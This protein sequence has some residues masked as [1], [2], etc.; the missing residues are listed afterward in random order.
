MKFTSQI[1]A[2]GSGSIGGCTYSRNR[3]GQYI[4]R[5]AMPV[6]PGS[7]FAQVMT[8][9][10][11]A[12]V[13][14]WTTTLTQQQ[15]DGWDTWALNTPQTDPLGNA[16]VWTGQNAY[17]SMNS[18]RLQAGKTY[19]DDA[20]TIFAGATYTP[21][22]G[23]DTANVSEA[24]QDFDFN[25][26]NTDDWAN[27]VGGVLAVYVSRPQNPSVN[28]FKG[29]YRLAA[30]EDGAVVPPTSPLTVPFPFPVVEDQRIFLQARV[31]NAD[32][33]IS[34]VHR[35]TAICGA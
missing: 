23:A 10:F 5:R 14:R 18:F 21:N 7:A 24:S 22:A 3:S 31:A 19:V 27:A 34:A 15:R 4:R 28:Y 32:G 35:F 8:A 29:P 17:I 11:A 20:P 26:V 2:S 13:V 25:F 1:I 33:R 30:T 16:V 6:N 12:L 9:T